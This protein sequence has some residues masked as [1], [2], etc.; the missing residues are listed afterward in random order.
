M[1]RIY[2]NHLEELLKG[3]TET[4]IKL[5]YLSVRY[6]NHYKY[7]NDVIT[8][9]DV[10]S[11]LAAIESARMFMK[12]LSPNQL[13]NLFP[14]DKVYDGEKYCCK[15]YF[16]TMNAL[17]EYDADQPIGEKLDD[18]LWDYE[19]HSINEFMVNYL[20]T[21]SKLRQMNGEKGLLEEWADDNDIPTYSIDKKKG[22][23]TNNQT[24][25]TTTYEKP[26]P[27]YLRV[28]K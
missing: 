3:D 8:K 27:D 20:S 13:V 16:Y 22:T 26:M 18:L 7:P 14:I 6:I 15:D 25:E 19:N 5:V 21:V 2:D 10:I 23:I 1:R 4:I 24:G 12:K 17:K 11:Y 9:A 28:V